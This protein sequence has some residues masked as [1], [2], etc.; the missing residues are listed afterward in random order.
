MRLQNTKDSKLVI[1]SGGGDSEEQANDGSKAL[2]IEDIQNWFVSKLAE[3][4]GLKPEEIDI[5]EPFASYGL[6]SMTMVTLS[7]DLE[8]WLGLR[9]APTLAWDYPTIE[10]LAQYLATEV[11]N[12]ASSTEVGPAGKEF[13]REEGQAALTDNGGGEKTEQLLAQVGELT[14]AQVDAL[15]NEMQGVDGRV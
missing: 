12:S 7:G 11:N 2:S 1:F 9:L 15:L 14:E 6:D 5:H 3:E 13:E 10:A 8:E 4:L